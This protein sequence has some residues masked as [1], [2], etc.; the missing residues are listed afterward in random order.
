GTQ[1]ENIEED[2]RNEADAPS[3]SHFR[4]REQSPGVHHQQR[5][6]LVSIGAEELV[7]GNV[8]MTLGKI[9]TIILRFA[10]QDISV[11]GEN[12]RERSCGKIPQLK[13]AC[14]CG[15]R[16]RPPPT[17]TSTCRT[18]NAAGRMV[19]RNLIHRHRPDLIDFS[20]F[21]KD[22]PLGN[23]NLAIKV[24]E[25][26]LDMPKMLDE[27]APA[28][29]RPNLQEKCE[30]EANF[31][32]NYAPDGELLTSRDYKNASLTEV[33]V[34]LRRRKASESDLAAHQ[35]RVAQIAQELNELDYHA[36]AAIKQYCQR[37]C[38]QTEK[39]L[40]TI[41]QLFLE[42]AK[43]SAPFNNWMDGVI[44]DLQDM[45]IVH[46]VEEVQVK[47]LV[48][49][50]DGALQE[51]FS[52]QQSNEGVWRQFAVQANLTGPWIHT[53]MEIAHSSVDPGATLEDHMNHLQTFENMVI[54][55]KANIDKLDVENQVIQESLIFDNK[56]TDYTM[57]HICVG[58]ELLL[59][60]KAHANE[61][62]T[63]ILTCDTKG[64]SQKQLSSH[65]D[66]KKNGGMETDEFRARLIS[67]GYD[68][69]RNT[70]AKLRQRL[71]PSVKR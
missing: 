8:K 35:H 52:R 46:S 70:P 33:R 55:Y 47:R 17:V 61:V 45:F 30:L 18:S 63:Q 34:L 16:E 1:L 56:H 57:E 9:S 5:V 25:N 36:S 23:L 15:A 27:E 71:T 48:P 19:F 39:L 54:N 69:V 11:E 6:K 40:E 29:A 60:T 12:A 53:H 4:Q 26:Y 24:A 44:E 68:L 10:I 21:N 13:K 67:T 62:Q 37:I 7:D 20:K 66:R 51:E 38:D 42:F 32:P 50:R 64:M 58:W 28:V 41:H 65:F 3:G 43:R 2:F 49:H 22:D 14:S 31:R 59:T